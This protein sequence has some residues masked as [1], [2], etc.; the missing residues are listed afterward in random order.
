MKG[1]KDFVYNMKILLFF[2]R[3]KKRHKEYYNLLHI[4]GY[5]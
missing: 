1:S 3:A 5:Y 4:V 2:V